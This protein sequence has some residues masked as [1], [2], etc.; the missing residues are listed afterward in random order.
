[1]GDVY[2]TLD[3]SRCFYF[4]TLTPQ[5]RLGLREDSVTV[6][7]DTVTACGHFV[8]PNRRRLLYSGLLE[9]FKCV[10]VVTCGSRPVTPRGGVA[11]RSGNTAIDLFT[12]PNTRLSL[13]SICYNSY[14]PYSVVDTD[15]DVD[16]RG[17]TFVPIGWTLVSAQIH[18][19]H[20]ADLALGHCGDNE[21]K[22]KGK[23]KMEGKL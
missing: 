23:L 13:P 21:M 18:E 1:M 8:R 10:R 17:W 14:A 9:V 2:C 12:L 16:V 20:I 3:F 5:Q 7:A 19:K 22:K 11:A 4:L 6:A 15:T